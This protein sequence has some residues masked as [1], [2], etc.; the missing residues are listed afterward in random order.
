MRPLP[1]FS[2]KAADPGSCRTF[3]IGNQLACMADF[4]T[5]LPLFIGSLSGGFRRDRSFVHSPVLYRPELWLTHA[6]IPRA[7]KIWN[8]DLRIWRGAS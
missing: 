5:I 7:A 4:V 1:P 8:Y 2:G 6:M 3:T